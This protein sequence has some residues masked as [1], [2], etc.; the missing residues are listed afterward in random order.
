MKLRFTLN[1]QEVTAEASPLDRLLDVLR[2]Q[3][4]YVGTKEGCGEGEC[5][6]CSVILNGKLVNSCLV[7][8]LQVRG[9]DVLTI[10][11]RIGRRRRRISEGLRRGRG[12]A[13]RILHPGD[14]LGRTGP[15]KRKTQS[16]QRGDKMGLG[17]KPLSMHRLRTD[18]SPHLY[19][20]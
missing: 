2:E 11:G 7:P 16:H 19:R 4:G 8:A 6:A 13:V 1:G 18:I 17:G 12:G 15:F 14:G 5:G 10:E 3:L 20:V 9:G